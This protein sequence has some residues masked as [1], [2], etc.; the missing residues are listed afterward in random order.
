MSDLGRALIA[1]LA[2]DP[3]TLD[4]LAERVAA[5]AGARPPGAQLDRIGGKS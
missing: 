2:D 3:A 4:R 5:R 1:E